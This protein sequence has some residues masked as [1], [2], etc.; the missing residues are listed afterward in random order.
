MN[1]STH[2]YRSL[3]ELFFHRAAE[4]GDRTFLHLQR[5]RRFE[6]VSWR[7]FAVR[8]RDVLLGLDASGFAPGDVMAIIGE[9]RIEWL[10]ADLATLAGGFPNVTLSPALSDH[11]LVRLLQHSGARAAFVEGDAEAERLLRHEHALRDLRQIFVMAPDARSHAP[12]TRAMDELMAHTGRR[13]EGRLDALLRRA[14]P[15]DTASIMYTSGSTGE[16]KGV[17][18]TQENI[19]ANIA[20]GGEIALNRPDE[21]AVLMLSLNHLFGRFGFH[22]SVATGRTTAVVEAIEKE[23]EIETIRALA[24]TTMSLVPRVIERIFER[25]LEYGDNRKHW[26]EIDTLWHERRTPDFLDELPEI[27]ARRN[28]LCEAV[29]A[30]LGGRLKYVSYGGAPVSPH[31]ARFFQVVRIPLIGSYGSTECGGVTVSGLDENDPTNLGKPFANV[32]IRLADDGELLVRG[33]TVSPGYFR[34]PEATREAFDPDGWYHTGD[35]GEISAGGSLRLVGRKKDVFNCADG[36]N[37]YPQQIEVLLEADPCIRQAILIGD[38]K[39]FITALVVP[40]ME[41]VAS[42]LGS[43][44]AAVTGE[45]ARETLRQRIDRL[46]EN[47]EDF[48]KVR[49][50]ALIAHDFPP[51]VRTITVFQ[52]VKVDRTAVAKEYAAEIERLYAEETEQD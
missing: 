37:I 38:R 10:C 30:L 35:L 28:T 5:N 11:M 20:S 40:E 48:E 25:L 8:V 31:V 29:R 23:A 41:R 39:P 18:R 45:A 44:R 49:D 9:N 13:G 42:E 51:S 7:D 24:P 1:E 46:N 34:N 43:P 27:R 17:I 6:E 22:K 50:I 14:Q 33:P 21:T 4:L 16:P 47:L 32:E 12:R 26:H 2:P 52:K 36:T 15:G 3:G 19:V